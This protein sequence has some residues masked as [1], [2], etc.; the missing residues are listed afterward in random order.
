MQITIGLNYQDLMNLKDRN[1]NRP[2]KSVHGL[3]GEQ[4]ILGITPILNF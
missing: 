1:R 3:F 2:C 4:S